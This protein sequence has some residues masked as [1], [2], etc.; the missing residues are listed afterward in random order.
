MSL[1]N[2]ASLTPQIIGYDTY[3]SFKARYCQIYNPP[4]SHREIITG[5]K[6]VE[7]LVA[8]I[9]PY[10]YRVRKEDCLTL[11]P[12]VYRRLPFDLSPAER[13]VYDD[14]A[15]TYTAELR[16]EVITAELALVRMTRLQQIASGWFPGEECTKLIDRIPS[17]FTAL[18]GVLK[19]N[20]GCKAI[21]WSRFVADITFIIDQLN[22]IKPGCALGY[23]GE[24]TPEQRKVARDRFQNDPSAQFL[25]AQFQCA[26]RGLTL[27]AA[28]YVVYYTN[29]YS[30]GHEGAKRGSLPPD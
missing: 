27:T 28:E 26:S 29:Q 20:K 22:M 8:R 2:I 18:L 13:L 17:R 4:D 30:P 11:P 14:L 25:V 15:S 12:K 23:W 3:T 16:D 6:N 5:Y 19:E 10:S 7:E 24:V 9:D 1:P 21:I